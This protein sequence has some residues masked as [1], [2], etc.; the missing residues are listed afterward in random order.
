MDSR[1]FVQKW[2]LLTTGVLFALAAPCA[3]IGQTNA[4]KET[5]E[6]SIVRKPGHEDGQAQIVEAGK[7]RKIT[8]HATDAWLARKG[9]A[10]LVIVAEAAKGDQ[11]KQHI[12]RYYDLDSGR[13]RTLGEVPFAAAS[14]KETTASN[15]QWTFALAG[16]DAKT[17][18]PVIVVG[19]DRA[20]T[21]VLFNASAPE[22]QDESLRYAVGN[23]HRQAKTGALTGREFNAIYAAP[24]TDINQSAPHLLQVFPNGSAMMEQADDAVIKTTWHTDGE[25]LEFRGTKGQ[26]PYT[27]RIADLKTVKGVPANTQFSVRLTE[28]LSSRTTHE[29][30]TIQAVLISPVVIH[31]EILIPIGSAIEGKVVQADSTGWGFKHE[32]ASLTLSW[33]KIKLPDGRELGVD[34]RVYEVENAQEKVTD[35][36]KIQGIR[37]TG[38][39]GRTAENGVLAFAGI[40]PI[41]YIFA[42]ASGSGVLGFA[43]PEILYHAGTELLLENVKPIETEHAYPPSVPPQAQTEEQ[44]TELQ[45]L[46]K[47]LPYRTRT[48]GSNKVSDLTNLVF[49]GSAAGLERAFQAAGWVHSE[50]LTASST[51]K[52]IKTI[53]GNQTYTQAPMSVLL[54]DEREPIFALSK[55][56]NVFSSRH[57][58]RVFPT[59]ATREGHTV[60]TA[61]STQDIG[62]AFSRKQKTFIHVIDEHIDNERSKVV[63]DLVFTGCV[64]SLDMVPRP[65]VPHDAYNSTGDRLLTDGAAAVLRISDCQNPR[66]TAEIP[67]EPPRRPQRIVRDT[68]LTIRS[69]LFRGN[70]IYQ[71][72]AGGRAFKHYLDSS[73]ELPADKGAWRMTDA[74]G[75]QY[76]GYGNVAD[77]EEQVHATGGLQRRKPG[78]LPPPSPEDLAA[79]EKAKQDHKWDPPRYELALQGGYMHMRSNYLTG[80][81]VIEESSNPD[82]PTYLLIL[83]D[84]INDGWAAGGSVTL[85][86]WKH[87]SNEF[88]YF[89]QQIKYELDTLNLT[90]S[91]SGDDINDDLELDAI[92]IGLVTRQFEYNLLV[93]PLTPKHRLRPYAAVGPVFQ[94]LALNGA[95]LK[96]PAGV[97]NLGLKNIGLIK[98]AFDFGHTPPLDGGGIFQFGLQYGAGVKYRV[99][100][101][102]MLRA[103]FRETWSANPD[104]IANSYEDFDP[105]ALDET[106]TTT[107]LRVKPE[108][109]F[110]QDRYT[111][112]VAF[113]F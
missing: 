44:K 43:E 67:A 45:S 108:T 4:A 49:V 83:Q 36:G 111:V 85:N 60:L 14:L 69:D 13:R 65:W 104:I 8:P 57:H 90:V 37:S 89:R 21:G 24:Q 15:D 102:L 78:E 101:R 62:I 33:T 55:T 93:H 47:T 74:S 73:R 30:D 22:F 91:N 18:H 63:D 53:S 41:A 109:K 51:F 79:I 95:P 56:T 107:V 99:L 66:T 48:Q 86:S 52:T 105:N 68:A 54:L 110:L 26:P 106:Y 19:S 34:A 42:S 112:G 32:T 3:L 29:G 75:A 84:V 39:H 87:F 9:A 27:V 23:E 77:V 28:D 20:L 71:G 64:E 46:V 25:A 113:T 61:S 98:A 58:I 70:L 72:I 103:D 35:K 10:A 94:M 16:T 5:S 82:N 50:D 17:S 88:S 40:D 38:T 31:G 76:K 81:A 6:I 12:L 59:A 80:V 7:V 1:A 2:G 92:P 97:F 11:P 100:P 96:K